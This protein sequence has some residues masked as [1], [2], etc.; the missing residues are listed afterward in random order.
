MVLL[1]SLGLAVSYVLTLREEWRAVRE[2]RDILELISG[3]I[4]YG[5][6]SL[7]E[8]FLQ[9]GMQ[10]PT[11]LGKSFEELGRRALERPQDS[12]RELLEDGLQEKLRKVLPLEE[13]HAFFEFAAPKGYQ[14]EQMQRR[15]LDRSQAR[16]EE[17]LE[18][19]GEQLRGKS[20]V[21]CCLGIMGGLFL[22]LFLW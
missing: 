14:D 6:T 7:P 9:V 17:L 1:G 13:Y 21:A 8:C 12:L 16:I 20:R 22:I 4:R 11:V 19:R 10:R 5:R 15:A 2:L 18:I 3:E